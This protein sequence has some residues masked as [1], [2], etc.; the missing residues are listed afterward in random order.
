MDKHQVAHDITIS[1]IKD[2]KTPKEAVEK[3]YE[4]YPTVKKEIE[5]RPITIPVI[6][7]E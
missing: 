4:L 3:Y 6:S 1:L 2:C 5:S 7:F